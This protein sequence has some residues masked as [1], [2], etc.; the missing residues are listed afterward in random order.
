MHLEEVKGELEK[1]REL[2]RQLQ[3]WKKNHKCV[4]NQNEVN[5]T[6]TEIVETTEEIVDM[7]MERETKFKSFSLKKSQGSKD[8]L[9]ESG[10]SFV[11]G[12]SESIQREE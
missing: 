12:K 1:T 6:M 5:S 3:L 9:N 10:K 7:T 4:G 8:Q 2:L 11:V